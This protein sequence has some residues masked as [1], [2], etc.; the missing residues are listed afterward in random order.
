M[1]AS[2]VAAV[3]AIINLLDKVLQFVKNRSN[4]DSANIEDVKRLF[5]TL[6]AYL[7]DTK[8]VEATEG[9]MV[10][11]DQLSEESKD[12]VISVI[13]DAG[14]VKTTLIREVYQMIKKVLIAMLGFP[15][16]P[17]VRTC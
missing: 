3:N 17:L 2:A 11:V 8:G 15:S 6:I 1:A 10:R 14:S 12:M 13:G 7:T 5:C 4:G 16:Y 9:L